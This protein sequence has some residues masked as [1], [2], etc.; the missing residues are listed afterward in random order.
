MYKYLKT[1]ESIEFEIRDRVARIT[2]N[3]PD[4]RNALS[5]QMI[6]ELEQ[7]LIEADAR[8][9]VNVIVSAAFATFEGT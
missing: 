3:R 7:A 9:D 5:P 4:K 8:V 6:G 2:L 1:T